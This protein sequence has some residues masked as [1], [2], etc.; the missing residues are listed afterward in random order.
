MKRLQ[1]WSLLCRPWINEG[2]PCFLWHLHWNNYPVTRKHYTNT[3]CDN[4]LGFRCFNFSPGPQRKQHWFDKIQGF[5]ME[6]ENKN[7]TYVRLAIPRP[8]RPLRR[9]ARIYY[10]DSSQILSIHYPGFCWEPSVLVW[11]HVYVVIV[12]LNVNSN[13]MPTQCANSMS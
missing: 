7:T 4:Y 10:P 11:R 12:G 5:P 9:L 1:K 3:L 8:L 6:Y 13:S 2:E